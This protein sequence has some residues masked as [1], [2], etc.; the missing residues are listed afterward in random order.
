MYT[1]I[2]LSQMPDSPEKSGIL[3]VTKYTWWLI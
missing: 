2:V 3:S 1:A